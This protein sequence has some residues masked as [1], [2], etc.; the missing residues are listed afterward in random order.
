MKDDSGSYGAFTEQRSSASPMTAAKIMDI[1]SRLPS[2]DRQA[3]DA[4]SSYTQVI[5]GSVQTFG[6]VH[7]DTSGHNLGP[8][9][10]IQSFTLKESVRSSF[11]KTIVGKII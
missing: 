9:W 6:F 3:R 5:N 7:H 10:K 8:V 4:I 2:C 1:I 11:G